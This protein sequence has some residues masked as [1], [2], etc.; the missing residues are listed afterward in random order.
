MTLLCVRV[1]WAG[2]LMLCAAV[3]TASHA[4]TFQVAGNWVCNVGRVRLI[5]PIT[6]GNQKITI[7]QAGSRLTLINET[8][9]SSVG[10]F[11]DVDEIAAPG[12][13]YGEQGYIGI[14]VDGTFYRYKD[15]IQRFKM[16]DNSPWNFI[17]WNNGHLCV[18]A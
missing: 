2:A 8:G 1:R 6:P 18:R 14:N 15:A 12:W 16:P 3:A 13:S 7:E 10:Q 9:Q 4:Q 17:R 11:V 5:P